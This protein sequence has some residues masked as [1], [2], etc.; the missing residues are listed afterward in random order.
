[1][2]DPVATIVIPNYNGARF[3]PDLLASLDRQSD[4]RF[5]VLVVDDCSTD[6]GPDTD[7]LRRRGIQFLRNECNLGFAGTCNAGIRQAQ[8]PWVALLNNDTTVDVDWFAAAAAE[9]ND[10]RV[11][12]IASL[13]LLADPPHRID[14]AGDVYSVAGG[15]AKRNHLAPRDSAID[16]ADTCFSACGASAFYRRSALEQVGLLDDRFIS[17]YE[18]VDLGFRLAW[19]GGICR[20]ARQSVCYHKLSASY[21]PTGWAYHFNSA[22]NAEIVWQSMMPDGLQRRYAR[23]RRAFLGIQH[24][25]KLRQGCLRPYRAGRAEAKSC[26]A[27][28]EERRRSRDAFAIVTEAEIERRLERDWFRLHVRGSMRARGCA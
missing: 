20:F 10:R 7:A 5:V 9:F 17:Y 18:D 27:W 16:L 26:A 22:R 21:S 12:S 11:T 28:I 23:A 2:P 24:L 19:A 13:V 3:L 6:G 8:T 1:M 4:R 25:N 15:A 14:S